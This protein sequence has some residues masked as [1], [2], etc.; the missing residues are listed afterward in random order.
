ML[1]LLQPIKV[2][3]ILTNLESI[4]EADYIINC[5]YVKS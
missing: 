5:L 4:S 1:F 3:L 2:E